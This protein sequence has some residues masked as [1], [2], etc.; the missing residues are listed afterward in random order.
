MTSLALEPASVAEAT[1]IFLRLVRPRPLADPYPQYRRLRGLAPLHTVRLPGLGTAW[2]AVSHASVTRL[3]RHRAFGPLSQI[4][5]DGL[6]PGWRRHPFT[7]CLYQA[8]AFQHGSAHRASRGLVNADFGGRA[9]LSHRAMITGLVEEL[10]DALERGDDE[11]DLMESLALPFGVLAISR[12]LGVPDARALELAP[13]LRFAGAVFEPLATAAQRAVQHESGGRVL[14]LLGGLLADR[15]REPRDDL[16]SRL[17]RHPFPGD[18]REAER[19]ALGTAAMLLIAGADSPAS[20]VGL[21]TRLLLE[22]PDQ[23]DLLRATPSLASSAAEE[24]LRHDPPVQLVVRTAHE[25]TELAGVPVPR[26]GVVFGLLASAN[27]DPEAV[28]SP[29][30]FD[31]TRPPVP[32]LAFGA[33]PHYCLG[34]PLARLQA[35]VL[36][37]GLLRR[38][39][40]LRAAGPPVY[41]SPGTMLRSPD[42]LPV[43]LR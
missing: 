11:V 16:L 8:M 22:H 28:S 2:T 21:G 26:G 29:D 36:F 4:H 24:L 20:L 34:A 39:P 42:R 40:A 9:V 32:A 5:L 31:I 33:G 27:R 37:P 13:L 41:R 1:R 25:D 43:S 18:P 14:D 6:S 17:A 38:F 10:L 15:R 12:V 35:E 7:S 3:L 23:A 30:R 19:A